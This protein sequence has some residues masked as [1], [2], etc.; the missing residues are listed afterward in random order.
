MKLDP[1][2]IP[3]PSAPDTWITVKGDRIEL[4][5][6]HIWMQGWAHIKGQQIRELT[7]ERAYIAHGVVVIEELEIW[8]PLSAV[9]IGRKNDPK[10]EST[11]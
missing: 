5:R 1:N 7:P 4:T 9:Q 3:V 6:P 11:S 2:K 8:L 10:K